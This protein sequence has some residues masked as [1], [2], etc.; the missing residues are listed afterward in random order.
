MIYSLNGERC[1]SSSRLLVQASIYDE[2]TA[3]ARRAREAIKVGHP[4][5]PRPRS[6]R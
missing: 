1:T 6:D 2:F 3:R 4:L 5:D